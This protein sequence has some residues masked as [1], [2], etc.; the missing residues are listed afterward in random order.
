MVHYASK[1]DSINL[2][3]QVE[4]YPASNLTVRWTF[5]KGSGDQETETELSSFTGAKLE[6]NLDYHVEDK[7]SFGVLQCRASNVIGEQFNPCA[8]EVLPKGLLRVFI[9]S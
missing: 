1:G 6:S 5:V 8:F 9:E 2:S 4:A 3:C 7:N